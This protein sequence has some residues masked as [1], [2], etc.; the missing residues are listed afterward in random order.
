MPP[1]TMTTVT[2]LRGFLDQHKQAQRPGA[3]CTL[4]T[5]LAQMLIGAHKAEVYQ[6]P[7]PASQEIVMPM[8]E[9]IA[10]EDIKV[11]MSEAPPK[12]MRKKKVKGVHDG[13]H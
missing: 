10:T 3:V 5:R 1:D 9:P 13:D 12:E 2:V 7:A 4:P 11:F 6:P 8:T